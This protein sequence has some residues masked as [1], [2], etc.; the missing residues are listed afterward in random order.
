MAQPIKK[1]NYEARLKRYGN[2]GFAYRYNRDFPETYLL[3]SANILAEK[4]KSVYDGARLL[5]KDGENPEVYMGVLDA[6]RKPETILNMLRNLTASH[7]MESI[8][9]EFP[10]LA[11]LDLPSSSNTVIVSQSLGPL[12]AFVKEQ[13]DMDPFT[14]ENLTIG[15]TED[16]DLKV[17]IPNVSTFGE[18]EPKP[19]SDEER[20]CILVVKFKNGHIKCNLY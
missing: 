14:E 1:E 20:K 7:M 10:C 8:S 16:M 3:S 12:M 6:L 19:G 2:F 18:S 17:V 4:Y 13:V 9:R 15:T 5:M 11:S